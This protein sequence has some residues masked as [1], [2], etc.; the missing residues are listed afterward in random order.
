[1]KPNAVRTAKKRGTVVELNEWA[2]EKDPVPIR[3]EENGDRGREWRKAE[4]QKKE[5]GCAGTSLACE[6]E[7]G[8][9]RLSARN[10]KGVAEVNSMHEREGCTGPMLACLEGGTAE[11]TKKV[12]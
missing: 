7:G 9:A 12:G 8:T 1:M 11:G 2:A 6:V 5:R 3:S 4:G 10:E